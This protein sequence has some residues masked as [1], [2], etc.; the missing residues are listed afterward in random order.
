M[1]FADSLQ[2]VNSSRRSVTGRYLPTLDGWR[3]VA[4]A[5]VM[6]AHALPYHW[7]KYGSRGVSIFFGIS[8]FL[9]CSRLLDE[10][11]NSGRIDLGAF[12]LRRSFRILPP[13]IGYLGVL[14]ILTA[15][16][17][18]WVRPSELL[19]CLTFTRNYLPQP[20]PPSGMHQGWYTGHFWSLAVEE[21][22]YLIWPL[23]LVALGSARARWAVA[24]LALAIG[25]WRVIDFRYRFVE[26]VLP[27][28]SFY[29]RTDVSLDGLFWGCWLALLLDDPRWRACLQRGLT[30]L[31][32]SVSLAAYVALVLFQPP[33]HPVAEAVLIPI[34]LVGTVLH[35]ETIVGRVLEWEPLRWFGRLSYSLYLWQQL[36]LLDGPENRSP[37]LGRLQFL[38]ISLVAT[39]SC[40]IASFYLIEKPMI[41]LGHRLSSRLIAGNASSAILIPSSARPSPAP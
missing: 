5:G 15:A 31:T 22:F 35:P 2:P 41:R 13:Y 39:F 18:V 1:P 21:H 19:A 37:A 3:A 6:T 33:L 7:A 32:W 4:I 40:A 30:P 29:M 16:G 14:A 34:L 24:P 25:A 8:G 23:L 10:H 9:I 26:R 17:I 12:Y 11:R 36:F 38:P 20:Q 28:V 27:G